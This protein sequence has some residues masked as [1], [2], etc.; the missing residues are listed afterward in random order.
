[1]ELGLRP[2]GGERRTALRRLEGAS[3]AELRDQPR[4]SRRVQVLRF[5]SRPGGRAAARLRVRAARRVSAGGLAGGRELLHLSGAQLHDRRL[6]PADYAH[7]RSDC[8]LRLHRVLSAARGGSDRARH[9][10]PAA[11]PPSAHVRLRRGGDRL[12]PDALG[13]FQEV[14][15]GGQLRGCRE[16]HSERRRSPQ[17]TWHVAG[18]VP[19]HD[20]DLR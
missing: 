13:V 5:L 18:G 15:G 1:M 12:P 14:R 19:L 7:A 2:H 6:P 10:P 8:V 9:E 20:P 11:V 16:L 4:H 17:R 3:C